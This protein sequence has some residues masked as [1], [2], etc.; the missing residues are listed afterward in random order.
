MS[1][2]GHGELLLQLR[3]VSK[4][5]AKAG[6]A[7]RALDGVDLDVEEGEYLAL[8]GPSG[9]GKSTLMNVIGCLDQP[10]QGRF[11]FAGV[12]VGDL[13]PTQLAEHRRLVG[14]VFQSFHLLPGLSAV[15]NVALP[16]RYCGVAAPQRVAR[17]TAVLRQVGLGERAEHRPSELSGG[18]QQRVAVARALVADPKLVLAD[19]PTGNLDTKSGGEVIDL[20][21]SLWQ[22]GRTVIVVTHDDRLAARARR[23]VRMLD[24]KIVADQRR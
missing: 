17:A 10:T 9:S 14:F 24:G 18:Q 20:L 6:A 15:D 2:S 19:E 3:N 13:S 8:L 5:Y 12:D 22:Q 23:V 7:V 1:K 11:R 21:E 16:L 4:V